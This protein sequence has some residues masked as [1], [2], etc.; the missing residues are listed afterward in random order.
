MN[1]LEVTKTNTPFVKYTITKNGDI[2]I[3]ISEKHEN[4]QKKYE[5]IG[6]FIA[7]QLG[8]IEHTMRGGLR[9]DDSIITMHND[10]KTKNCDIDLSNC[11]TS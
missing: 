5:M 4:D 11:L 8:P 3:K 9:P 1:T 7:A 2:R 10:R 6:R